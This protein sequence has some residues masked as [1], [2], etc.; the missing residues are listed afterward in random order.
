MFLYHAIRRS[1]EELGPGLGVQPDG[2]VH[3][4]DVR[5]LER[6]DGLGV[7]AFARIPPADL[8]GRGNNRKI[9]ESSSPDLI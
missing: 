7:A 2:L 9:S 8:A 5:V 4:V 3:G 6:R 1:G